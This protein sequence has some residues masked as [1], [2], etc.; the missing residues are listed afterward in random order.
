MKNRFP[1]YETLAASTAYKS[2]DWR[3]KLI[4]WSVATISA[5]STAYANGFSHL[6][7]L[8][9]GWALILAALT[10]L[11]VEFSLYTLEE[12]LRST[13][14]GGT[15]RALAWSAKWAIKLTMIAN[16]A[17]VCC[18]I[19]G[20]A[21][22]THLLFWNRWSFAAHFAI[23]LILIPMIRDADPVITARQLQLRA[24]T[25]QEDQIVSRLTYAIASPC[26]LAG[27][28]IR[29]LLDGVA[30]GFRLAFNRQGFD[31]QNY[32]NNLN[33]LHRARYGHIEGRQ[34]KEPAD[35]QWP[36]E[37]PLNGAHP[38]QRLRR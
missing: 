33:S 14:K 6:S 18:V 10:L 34:H 8:G 7:R 28:R 25:A 21:P 13:F 32:L 29:G 38:Q 22:P 15:Q 20:V 26:A 31:A 16:A 12:G 36:T 24:E 37:I 4:T 1:A 30:L 9:L 5:I 2:I 23:G 11:I 35:V 17:F 3:L 27:A 19:A